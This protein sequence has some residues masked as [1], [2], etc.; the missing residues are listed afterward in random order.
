MQWFFRGKE[1]DDQLY[2]KIAVIFAAMLLLSSCSLNSDE[3]FHDGSYNIISNGTK[4]EGLH[5]IEEDEDTFSSFYVPPNM[6]TKYASKNLSDDELLIYDELMGTIGQFDK[7]TFMRVDANIYSKI[8]DMI[9]LEQLAYSQVINRYTG[10]YDYEHQ[11][12]ELIFDYRYN[13]PKELNDINIE[14]EKA[15]DEILTAITDDMSDYEKLKYFHDYLIKTCESVIGAPYAD[16]IYGTLICKKALCEGYAKTF[17]YLCNRVGIE[18]TIVVGKTTVDHMWN[19]VKLEG[20]WYHVD[21]TWDKPDAVIL[22][23]YPDLVLYQYFMVT[24]S[25]IENTHTLNKKLYTPPRATASKENYF[26]KEKQYV[27]SGEDYIKIIESSLINAV[28]NNQSYVM[29][30]FET[31]DNYLT[32]ESKFTSSDVLVIEDVIDNISRDFNIEMHI[33]WTP[34]YASYR[35]MLFIIEYNNN[36]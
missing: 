7:K 25:V 18:N 14:T 1:A 6:V 23:S 31:S 32:A 28:Q 10:D 24:D 36:P 33:S 4:S 29:V 20:N 3:D 2:K 17:S 27:K 16:T 22:E 19:M 30:K 15:A 34:Y 13:T 11:Q 8:L 35:T 5:E 26:I 9:R 21:V 12:F